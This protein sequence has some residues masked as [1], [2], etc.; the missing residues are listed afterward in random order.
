MRRNIDTH[1]DFK[2]FFKKYTLIPNLSLKH[3]KYNFSKLSKYNNSHLFL[4]TL[5]FNYLSWHKNKNKFYSTNKALA[6]NFKRNRFFPTIRTLSG[7]LHILIIRN[8]K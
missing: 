3:K 2:N 1:Y 8:V 5:T 6:L 7:D 4:T